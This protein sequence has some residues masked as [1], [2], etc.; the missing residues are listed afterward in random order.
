[1]Q[2][3]KEHTREQARHTRKSAAKSARLA[4]RL[5]T[6]QKM[7]LTRAAALAHQPLSQFIVASAINAAEETI[8]RHETMVLSTRDAYAVMDAL[9]HPKPASERLHRVA[10]RYRSFMQQG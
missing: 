7:I 4:A 8:R 5:S 6:D 3:L 1:M 2:A 9:L 10:E